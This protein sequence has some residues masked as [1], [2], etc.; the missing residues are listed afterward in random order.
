MWGLAQRRPATTSQPVALGWK[1]TATVVG[2]VEASGRL[3]EART[4]KVENKE[5]QIRVRDKRVG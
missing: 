5:A 4:S 2:T 1:L 3:E